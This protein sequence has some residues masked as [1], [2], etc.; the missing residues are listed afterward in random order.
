MSH[1]PLNHPL[2]PFYRTLAALVGVYVVVFGIVGVTQTS[3]RPMFDT[4]DTYA[5]GLR[6]NLA[7]SLLSIVAGVVLLLAFFAGRNIDRSVNL[8]GGVGFMVIGT[9]MM[10]VV[11]TDLNVL[12]FSIETVMVSFGIGLLLFTAGLYGLSGSA[13][14]ARAAELVRHGGH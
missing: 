12:N 2:R 8:W 9:A 5:L 10:A 6:T 13:D 3:G 11:R 14:E 4:G 1:M 7:F